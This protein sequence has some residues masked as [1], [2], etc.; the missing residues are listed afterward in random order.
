MYVPFSC[1]SSSVIIRL[2]LHAG[3]AISPPVGL[4][5]LVYMT[6]KLLDEAVTSKPTY[7]IIGTKDSF[8]SVNS[9]QNRAEYFREALREKG[10]S[11]NS[12][13][14]KIVDDVDHFWYGTEKTLAGLIEEW[15]TAIDSPQNQ[16]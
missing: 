11:E 13:S 8:S 15:L 10:E 3:V 1:V 7:W 12:Y 5:P 6:S 16:E 9:F 14:V 4:W 2:I